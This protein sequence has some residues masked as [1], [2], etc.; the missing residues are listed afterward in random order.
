MSV[1]DVV[2][3]TFD[4]AFVRAS[5]RC[6]ATGCRTANLDRN[7][8]ANHSWHATGNRVRL[9][10]LTALSYL[11][12][13]GV[14]LT[15]ALGFADR[16][17]AAL[18]NHFAYAVGAG[19]RLALRNHFA[20]R[21]MANLAAVLADH[22][23]NLVANFLGAA[24]GYHFAGGVVAHL[25]AVLANHSADLVG[26]L[27]GAAF[28]YHSANGVVAGF[29]ATFR[30]HLADTVGASLGAALRHNA[31]NSVGHLAGAAFASV[32]C[33][34]NFFLLTGWN[35]DFFADSLGW[36]LDTFGATFSRCVNTSACAWVEVPSSPFTYGFPHNRA[37]NCLGFGFP[38]TT[39]DSYRAR[40]LFRNAHTILFRSHF[41]FANSVVHG[42]ID[43]P[44]FGFVN[45]LAYGVFDRF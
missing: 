26:H 29:R 1:E 21:V 27:F 7:L 16:A 14:T 34:A 43:L 17:C 38:M 25:L 23:A 20:G 31:A 18:R 40:V 24:F 37:R 33:A 39:F 5:A 11:N 3:E 30:N 10:D 4:W 36:A 9:T 32:S 13:L 15:T 44:C 42:V 35:P 28:G 41:L 12:R 8:L 2:Q 45:R 6:G 19:F 22:L